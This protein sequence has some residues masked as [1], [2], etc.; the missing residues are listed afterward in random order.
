M[1]SQTWQET[2]VS[3]QAAGTAHNTFTTAVS[4]SPSGCVVSLPPN[5]W[6]IGRS[7]R[8]TVIGS[9]SNVVTTPG[10]INFNFEL[11]TPNI[12]AFASGAVFLTITAN[13]TLPFWAQCDVTCRSVGSGTAATLMGQWQ[14]QG[15]MF[16]MGALNTQANN[17]AGTGY[18]MGP[19]TAPAVGTGFDSTLSN[20]LDFFAGFSSSAAGNQI[21]VQQ[22]LIES[23]N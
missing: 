20:S 6:Y 10:S 17:A 3:A 4:C 5:W 23:L 21:Q 22:Y 7:V 2:L 12:A 8:M 19:A 13:T 14:G 9:I 11:G 15:I 18:F 16:S 1:S